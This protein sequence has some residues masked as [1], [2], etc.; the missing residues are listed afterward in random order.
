MCAP[1]AT[2]SSLGVISVDCVDSPFFM[3]EVNSSKADRDLSL[4][5][6]LDTIGQGDVISCF[7]TCAG[8]TTS[9]IHA[10]GP[11][12]TADFVGLKDNLQPSPKSVQRLE[13]EQRS[14]LE[15]MRSKVPISI[16]DFMEEINS[17]HAFIPIF[18]KISFS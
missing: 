4:S 7:I 12:C 18:A 11:S 6:P 10:D 16:F 13:R 3:I 14:I 1:S 5:R 17:F 9:F 15:H 2:S 8:A